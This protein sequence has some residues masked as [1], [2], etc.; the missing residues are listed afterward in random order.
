METINVFTLHA[1]PK[2]VKRY[3]QLAD[4]VSRIMEEKERY[5]NYAKHTVML[6]QN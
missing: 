2:D 4:K 1:E 5:G 3:G 6:N